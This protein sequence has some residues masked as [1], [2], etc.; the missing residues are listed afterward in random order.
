MSE[1]EGSPVSS[2][3]IMYFLY[4]MDEYHKEEKKENTKNHIMMSDVLI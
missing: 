4:T 2:A 3:V 1:G